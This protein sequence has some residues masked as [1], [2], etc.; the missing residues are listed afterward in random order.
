MIKNKRGFVERYLAIV[1]L[2]FVIL[3]ILGIFYIAAIITPFILNTSNTAFTAV[4]SA[5]IISGDSRIQNA[6]IIFDNT[7]TAIQ[8][9]SWIPYTLFIFLIMGFFG[10]A[11]YVRTERFFVFVW[12][13]FIII[14]LVLTI[15]LTVGYQMLI[16]DGS[17]SATT[18][19]SFQNQNFML[20]NLPWIVLGMGIL[21]GIV[22]F[23]LSPHDTTTQD[24]PL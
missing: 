22:L 12:I 11:Y 14:L 9:T 7:N 10:C 16:S 24:N 1:Y 8:G 6:T 23:I 5:S 4:H 17:Y 18:L 21:G 3:I 2:F 13:F 19:Q 15:S 20:L